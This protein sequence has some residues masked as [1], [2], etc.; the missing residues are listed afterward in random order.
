MTLVV[1]DTFTSASDVAITAHTGETGATWAAHPSD[2]SGINPPVV[3]GGSDELREGNT[4]NNSWHYASGSPANAD[5]HA[6][7]TFRNRAS[8]GTG[9]NV[10]VGVRMT[11]TNPL[12]AYLLFY[13]NAATPYF[14]LYKFAGAGPT[15]TQLGSDYTYTLPAADT[16]VEFYVVGSEIRVYKNDGTLMISATDTAITAAG[17]L[18]VRFSD[19]ALTGAT[20]G[21]VL[22]RIQ[23][24]DGA[25]IPDPQTVTVGTASETDSAYAITMPDQTV[26]VGTASETDSAYTVGLYFDQSL[27]VGVASETDSA[28]VI[29]VPSATAVG[30]RFGATVIVTVAGL[31]EARPLAS[32][33]L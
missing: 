32:C 29:V 4:V 11:T 3:D 16:D 10:V 14:R 21:I 31:A 5:W 20:G 33:A 6:T 24:F 26:N 15:A 23:G 1:E 19:V 8:A 30:A 17:K 9:Q 27:A 28:A 2:S 12:N 25:V 22:T 13:V 18:G 7:I